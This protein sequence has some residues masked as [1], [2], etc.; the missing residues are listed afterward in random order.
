MKENV[1]TRSSASSAS[2]SVKSKKTVTKKTNTVKSRS[3]T[4]KPTS[5]T[6]ASVAVVESSESRNN[7]RPSN[8]KA[9]KRCE[10]EKS[11]R[12]EQSILKLNEKASM[13][14][15]R[16]NETESDTELANCSSKFLESISRIV[17]PSLPSF[18]IPRL[19]VADNICKNLNKVEEGMNVSNRD[20]STADLV[21]VSFNQ[22]KFEETTTFVGGST[23]CGVEN[24]DLRSVIDSRSRA[25]S[26]GSSIA[27]S[28]LPRTLGEY[29]QLTHPEQPAT[30]LE[31]M[32]N[33]DREI[34][35]KIIINVDSEMRDWVHVSGVTMDNYIGVGAAQKLSSNA[36]VHVF[37][38]RHRCEDYVNNRQIM[39]PSAMRVK[40]EFRVGNI[41]F[42]P[43]LHEVPME[44]C[45]N[46]AP[47]RIQLGRKF[48]RDYVSGINME[49]M[50]LKLHSRGFIE[51]V[52]FQWRRSND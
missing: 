16:K 22:I 10:T 34:L 30:P 33:H 4:P 21:G 45:S 31:I 11:D 8:E 17:K 48:V 2:S 23:Q 24:F 12:G 36:Q 46:Y 1:D 5:N 29:R 40:P 25:E 3:K 35:I 7:S 43:W 44:S 13:A 6:S 9:L 47:Q 41:R 37:P 26:T 19:S 32:E 52:P 39:F 20:K 38:P 50:V 27:S 18:K 42:F 49:S 51:E 14:T 15:K 28:P